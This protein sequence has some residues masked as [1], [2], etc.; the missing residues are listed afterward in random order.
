MRKSSMLTTALA[1][2]LLGVFFALERRLRQGQQAQSLDAGAGIVLSSNGNIGRSAPLD[3]SGSGLVLESAV[4]VHTHAQS[5]LGLFAR[6]G[7]R[8][9]EVEGLEADGVPLVAVDGGTF[10]VDYSGV[11]LR[12]GVR[13]GIL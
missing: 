13:F 10:D 12:L 9:A 4:T 8:Y 6:A 7:Y 1:Y 11:I 3:L 2:L 5:R